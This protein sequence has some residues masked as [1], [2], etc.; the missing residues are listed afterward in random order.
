[1][2]A[3]WMVDNEHR[4]QSEPPYGENTSSAIVS[5]AIVSKLKDLELPGDG[6]R[7]FIT[8]ASSDSIRLVYK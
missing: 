3:A 4:N 5:N 6:F 7:G 1:M 8:P 2:I